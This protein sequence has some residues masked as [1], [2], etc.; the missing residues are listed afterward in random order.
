[1]KIKWNKKIIF[2]IVGVFLFFL[3]AVVLPVP[4]GLKQ[5]AEQYGYSGKSAMIVL[6]SL[7]WAICWWAGTVIPDW[8]TALGLQCIWILAAG[9]SFTDAFSSFSKSTVWLIVGAFSLSSAIT[10]T[11]LLTRI[12]L[13]L[14]RL[15]PA[16]FRGQVT[17]M[18]TV[19]T[20]CGPLMPSTTAKVVLGSRL[21]SS[22]ADLM[23]Y[24]NNSKARTGL[25]LASWSGFVLTAP[26]FLS[27]SFLSYS[28]VTALPADYSAISW[29][30]WFLAMLPWGI[31]I[32]VA[33]YLVIMVF[34]HPKD[35]TV[36]SKEFVN[37]E[38]AALGKTSKQEGWGMR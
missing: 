7:M 16:S 22:S 14:M 28:L 19:G 31:L 34:Y 30:Q 8:N 29:F 15:F 12:S 3:I 23:Q 26:L 24:E 38:C 27:A 5:A 4:E 21:A 18:M 36:F 33:M 2:G 35:K 25:F 11:G 37:A 10:K 9:L 20:I 32:F 17:A 1:M 6:G 13:Q